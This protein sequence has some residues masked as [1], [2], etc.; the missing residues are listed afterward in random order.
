[1]YPILGYIGM[2]LLAVLLI[3]WI[4]EKKNILAEKLIR[5]KMI[6]LA[7]KKYDEDLDYTKKDKALFHRLGEKSVVDTEEIKSEIKNFVKETGTENLKP[8]EAES[9]SQSSDSANN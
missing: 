4:K 5:K 7:V 1:M 2:L 3:S 8:S 6:H 9:Q